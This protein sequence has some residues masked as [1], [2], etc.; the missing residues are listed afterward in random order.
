ME[1]EKEPPAGA[2]SLER[3]VRRVNSPA[4]S[5]RSLERVVRRW[6]S[7]SACEEKD[8]GQCDSDARNRK[9]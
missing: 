6:R 7:V 5:L 1:L 3:V 9:S 2:C 8:D 4:A